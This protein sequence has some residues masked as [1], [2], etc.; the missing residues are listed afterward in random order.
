MFPKYKKALAKSAF[1]D[2]ARAYNN[3]I[4]YSKSP[5]HYINFFTR[6]AFSFVFTAF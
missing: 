5:A 4:K 3:I 2:F 6:C 1:S